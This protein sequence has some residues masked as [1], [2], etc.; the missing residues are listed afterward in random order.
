MTTRADDAQ[1]ERRVVTILFA[2]V[3]GFTAM[4][5]R[6][7]PEVVTD[8]MNEI[9][10]ALGAEVEATGGHVDK[11]IGDSLMALF[12]APTAHEDDAL[13]AVR[14][15]LA[16]HRAME[17]RGEPLRRTLGRP[18]RLRI[19]IHSGLVV[20][21]RVG[22]PGQARATVMG[23]AVN[24][25]ARLQRAA[26]EGG[27]LISDVVSRQVRGAY[28]LRAWAPIDVKGKGE[29]VPVFE[30][31]AAQEHPEPV[32]RPPFVD[33]D[34]ELRAL[35]DLRG[36]AARG[37]AQVV[38]V[39]GEPGIGKTRVVEEFLG[40]L[41]ADAGRL[42]ASCPAYGGSSLGPLAD[43]F[44]QLA[45]LGPRVTLAELEARVPLGER[46]PQA[47]SILARL[48][49][50]TDVPAGPAD[51]H[52]TALLVAAE[53]IRRMIVRPTAVWI[54]DAQWAD[55]GTRELLPFMLDRMPDAPL[56]L[57]VTQRPDAEPLAW[58][59]RTTVTT[60]Q[61]P[62]L[63]DTDARALLTGLL[64]GDLPAAAQATIVEKA[65]GNPFYL[66]ELVATLTTSGRLAMDE[67]GRWQVRGALY[68]VLPESVHA[69]V[70]A[71]LDRL[72]P[73]L[74]SAFQR[75]AVAG[76]AFRRSLLEALCP[77]TDVPAALRQ[78]EAADLLRARDPLSADPEYAFS[79]PLLREAAYHAL[80]AKQRAALHL[81]AAEALEASA[82]AGGEEPAKALATHFLEAGRPERAVPYLLRAG[83]RAAGRYAAREAIALL[84]AARR[85]A[86]VAGL[87]EPRVEACELLGDLYLRVQDRGP[88]D[89]FAVWD[90]VRAHV[91]PAA[92]PLRHARAAV[93]AASAL[94]HDNRLD[95]AWRYLR[96]AEALIPVDDPLASDLH[97]VRAH[98]LIMASEYRAALDAARTAVAIADARG[99]LTD[100]SR[101]YAALAH[102]AILPLLGDEGRRLMAAW[103]AE[104]AAS[105]DE[106]LLIEAR[107]YLVSDVWTRG[108]AD[109]DLL[110]VAEDALRRAEEHG[111]TRDEA[112]LAQLVGWARFLV[113]DWPAAE[114]HVAR[115]H[116]LTEE[117]GGRLQGLYTI[118]LPLLRANLAMGAGR[119][120]EARAILLDALRYAR[121]HAPIWL[122][123]DLARCE[124]MLGELPR[125]REAM[126]RALEA[127]DR[128]KCIICGCQADGIAAEFYARLGEAD[129]AGPLIVAA[130]RTA[131]EIGHVATA[132]RARRAAAWVALRTGATDEVLVAAQEAVAL[133]AGLP[134]RQPLE[135]GQS[136]ALLAEV[137]QVAG[138]AVR[139]AAARAEAHRMFAGL[140]APWFLERLEADRGARAD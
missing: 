118:L 7:D 119:L 80:L 25:A 50:L 116:A 32:A 10:S 39:A 117:H 88:K 28:A 114:R 115:A 99:T 14:A 57:L 100:R 73:E 140:P 133:G 95:D 112:V 15:A 40:R 20:W 66:N 31:L 71:R 134:M 123:H 63:A 70:L 37:R 2:D 83:T 113:G 97:R 82:A 72:P 105:G 86:E 60:L 33:R 128:L 94:V 90:D 58:G 1:S 81:A 122:N 101:A 110:R 16:M 43:L 78:L 65:A 51:D 8:A 108:L 125:A 3:A 79:H 109:A 53:A 137:W 45:G 36:R 85:A 48:F 120:Q 49:D 24:L 104:A 22:P 23:D 139:A 98:A 26:P 47:A 21:G 30:V 12:G 29:P 92:A 111:W 27:V 18:V 84:E 44:R 124:W 59:R 132:I 138:D 91:D 56:L 17:A 41:P 129:R 93:R 69:A 96:E 77:G 126:A 127:R 89:W 54:E 11:V 130:W 121:F 55:A 9:F 107:H 52:E 102:P 136:Q 67:R 34:D 13:R 106:R 74:R 6:L 61:V 64:G 75:A 76:S 35:E 68:D 42:Q 103:V 87:V 38:M 135:H 46:A 19:G 4:S 5:E 62:P 131:R